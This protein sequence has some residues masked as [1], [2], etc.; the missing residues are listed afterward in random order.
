MS[1]HAG[2]PEILTVDGRKVRVATAGDPARPP[3]LLVHG[4]GRFLEDWD[5]LTERLCDDYR[6]IR[7][8]TPGF[9]H[10]DPLPGPV[11][12]RCL[13]RGIAP[14]LDALGECLADDARLEFEG[15]PVGPFAGREAIIAAYIERPPDDEVRILDAAEAEG[16][17]EAR[18]SWAVAPERQAG[19]MLVTLRGA[20]IERLVVTFEEG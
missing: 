15:V 11:D 16:G 7:L 17:V 5:E 19:R 1:T 13:G 2:S 18:Y 8:D 6:V 4:I 3:V 10:S 9:G 20:A 12:H 14:V